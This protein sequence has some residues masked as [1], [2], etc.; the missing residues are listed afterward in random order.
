MNDTELEKIKDELAIHNLL[1]KVLRGADRCDVE[2]TQSAY[3]PDATYSH[4]FSSGNAWECQAKNIAMLL[5]KTE[6]CIHNLGS[7]YLVIDGDVA[8]CESTAS[9]F[10]RVRSASGEGVSV[11]I[12]ARLL[13]RI[14]RRN[15]EW[16]IAARQ[17]VPE[18]QLN[19]EALIGKEAVDKSFSDPRKGRDDPS[20]ALLNDM[21]PETGR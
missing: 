12:H 20:Y 19:A 15:G 5:E 11:I 1:A 6:S 4:I 16:R 7:S 18:W 2:L 13:D 8:N 21:E 3:W 14:E 9:N 10:I 17:V